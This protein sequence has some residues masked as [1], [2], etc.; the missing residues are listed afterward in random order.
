MAALFDYRT[1]PTTGLR[2]DRA[3][4]KLIKANA[5]VAVVFL[6]IGG[7]FGLLVALTRW[8]AVHFLPADWFYLPQWKRTAPLRAAARDE[9]GGCLV[10]VDDLGLGAALGQYA[11]SLS[12]GERQKL[13][14]AR[15]L[16]RKPEV[17][18]LDEPCANLDGRAMREIE[19]ILAR[20][21]AAGTRLVMS[22]H[23]MGQARRLADEVVF[24][25][26]GRLLEAG[27]AGAFF[28]APATPEARAFL[29]G[30]ILE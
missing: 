19:E 28:D 24:L 17:L 20:T 7:L 29:N 2:V 13:A 27:P 9:A 14:L 11:L 21:L 4:E 6:A 10:F 8:P 12:G 26:Q 23:N 22:T 1:C 30:D 5:V 3:A 25:H 16:I 18:F 15:A